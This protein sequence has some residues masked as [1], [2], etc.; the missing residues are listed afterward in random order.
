M[1]ATGILGIQAVRGHVVTMSASLT[2]V[3]SN[4]WSA[5]AELAAAIAAR[6][7][8]QRGQLQLLVGGTGRINEAVAVTGAVVL[9]HFAASPKVGLQGGFTVHL[10]HTH[11]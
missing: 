6:E 1:H 8:L 10:K 5:G 9:G 3:L 2:R 4:R 11:Q 7:G